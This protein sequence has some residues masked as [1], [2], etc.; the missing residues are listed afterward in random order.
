[1][2][3]EGNENKRLLHAELQPKYSSRLTIAFAA[4]MVIVTFASL[5][6]VVAMTDKTNRTVPDLTDL[7]TPNTESG[8]IGEFD[9]AAKGGK[10]KDRKEPTTTSTTPT[11]TS[12]TPTSATLTCSRVRCT[13]ANLNCV[14]NSDCRQCV[15]SS[16]CCSGLCQT[17][18]CVCL[19]SAATC[20]K[21][22]ECCVGACKSGQCDDGDALLGN[23]L[24]AVEG[25]ATMMMSL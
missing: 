14:A 23:M 21:D 11:T 16:D 1:M 10:K 3:L 20:T 9:V 4:W 6:G 5:A 2:D 15:Q 19:A 8:V 18:S 12:T 25:L 24:S 13:M 17:G 22:E 7:S